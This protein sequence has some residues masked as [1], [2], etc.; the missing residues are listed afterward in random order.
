MKLG[1]RKSHFGFSVDRP[2]ME[3]DGSERDPKVDCSR[4]EGETVARWGAHLEIVVLLVVITRWQ[5]NMTS[6]MR[7]MARWREKM[8]RWGRKM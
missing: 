1:W 8:I 4:E 7:K 2:P 3:A 5:K 6:W